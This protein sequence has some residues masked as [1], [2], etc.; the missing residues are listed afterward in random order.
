MPT[1]S[2]VFIDTNVFV[3]LEDKR[4]STHQKAIELS[5]ILL[6]Q[7]NIRYITSSEVI[8][9]TMTVLSKKLGKEAVKIFLK[10][11]KKSNIAEIFF[12]EDLYQQTLKYFL[13]VKSKNTSFVDCSS[14]IAMKRNRIEAIFSFDEDFKKLGVKLLGDVIK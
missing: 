8:A 6:S 5:E 12:D 7:E 14:V 1:I 2:S 11:H 4:D 13:E 3:A 10:K 9:E